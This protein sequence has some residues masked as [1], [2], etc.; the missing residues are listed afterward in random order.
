MHFPWPLRYVARVESALAPG[1][2]RRRR[3]RGFTLPEAMNFVALAAV[4]S[5]LGMYALARYVKHA[6][7]AEAIGSVSAI[8]EA[9]AAYY[10]NSDGAQPVGT[11]PEAARAMRHF[12]P[13]SNG[14]V[15]PM[16]MVRGKRYQ[17]SLSDWNVPPWSDMRFSIPQP[18][19]YAY[20]FDSQGSGVGAKAQ[21]T[22]QG[23]LDGNGVY[24]KY[25]LGVTVDASSFKA[26]V[27]KEIEKMDPEE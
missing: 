17:S 11:T 21:V 8:A 25:R 6:K 1:R 10:E 22:A 13:P 2:R 3:V 23:D 5:A 20:A 18:Q 15:P 14:T 24:S 16:E 7:T 26:K 4:L 9:A 27:D 19:Y 12:P